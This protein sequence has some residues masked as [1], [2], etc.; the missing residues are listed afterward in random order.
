[1]ALQVQITSLGKKLI[2]QMSSQFLR[3]PRKKQVFSLK[4]K[5]AVLKRNIPYLCIL[6]AVTMTSSAAERRQEL[7]P[8]NYLG[9]YYYMG[10]NI[11][12]FG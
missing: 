6:N 5:F 2:I 1:M 8:Q 12:I 4:Q 9:K 7:E 11:Q 10:E 3:K